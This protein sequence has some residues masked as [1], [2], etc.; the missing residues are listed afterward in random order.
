MQT[1]VKQQ[2][3]RFELGTIYTHSSSQHV[4]VSRYVDG[5]FEDGHKKD[6]GDGG[7][8]A[9]DEDVDVDGN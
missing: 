4:C 6:D 7:D 1:R 9:N 8:N 5:F 2:T 3:K